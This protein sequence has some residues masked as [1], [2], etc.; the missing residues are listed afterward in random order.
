M[1]SRISGFGF[2]E[3]HSG[4]YCIGNGVEQACPDDTLA[5]HSPTNVLL[6]QKASM[7]L[8]QKLSALLNQTLSALLNT[9][10]SDYQRRCPANSAHIR[11][12]RPD[13]GLGF[14]LKGL[15]YF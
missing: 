13:S 12:A 4:Q 10:T 15:Q 6:N 7:L 2:R 3:C 14:Q 1:L 8:N 11:Q 9:A 5:G